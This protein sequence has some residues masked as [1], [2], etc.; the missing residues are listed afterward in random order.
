[1]GRFVHHHLPQQKR[2]CLDVLLRCTSILFPT[3]LPEAGSNSYSEFSYLPPKHSWFSPVLVFPVVDE[4]L[5]TSHLQS[6]VDHES[7]GSIAKLWWG[8]PG[9]GKLFGTHSFLKMGRKAFY[10]VSFVR[11]TIL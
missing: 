1:M 10:S 11:G 4:C 7:V 9:I 2:G 5:M 6:K 8:L 3:V